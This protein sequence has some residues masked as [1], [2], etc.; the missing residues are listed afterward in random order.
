MAV[1][2]NGSD[3]AVKRIIILGTKLQRQLK[4]LPR[5]FRAVWAAGFHTG[6]VHLTHGSQR[7]SSWLFDVPM[8]EV[9]AILR[10][11]PLEV[12]AVKRKQLTVKQLYREQLTNHRMSDAELKRTML[13]EGLGRVLDMLDELTRPTGN[14]HVV[15]ANGHAANDNN[16]AGPV[17]LSL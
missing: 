6:E 9:R 1:L 11:T 14:G 17:Q 8:S 5:S 12:E 3:P 4:T 13:R 2:D 16:I 7:Q 15:S 10:A